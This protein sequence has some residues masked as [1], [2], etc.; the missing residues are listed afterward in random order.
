MNPDQPNKLVRDTEGQKGQWQSP[1]R[2]GGCDRSFTCCSGHHMTHRGSEKGSA[3]EEG[4]GEPR[5]FFPC[6]LPLASSREDQVSQEPSWVLGGEVIPSKVREGGSTSPSLFTWATGLSQQFV[7]RSVTSFPFASSS[8]FSFQET[9]QDTKFPPSAKF[10][11][12]EK[13]GRAR[14]NGLT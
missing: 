12:K 7:Q 4:K 2:V 1:R 9:S 6:F 13:V 14:G 11:F 5:T 10:R 3:V 8:P